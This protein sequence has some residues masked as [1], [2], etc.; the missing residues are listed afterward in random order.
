MV[1][2]LVEIEIELPNGV[3]VARLFDDHDFVGLTRQ[4]ICGVP[5]SH[6]DGGYHPN[7]AELAGNAACRCDGGPGGDAIVDYHRHSSGQRKWGP[8]LTEQPRPSAQLG[9]FSLL[10]GL[11]LVF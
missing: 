8:A 1:G 3:E 7:G 2:R 9:T 10:Y 11:E 4:S 6:G 5:R